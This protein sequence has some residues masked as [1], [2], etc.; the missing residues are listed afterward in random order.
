M[1]L[2]LEPILSVSDIPTGVAVHGTNP[3][4]WASIAKNGLSKMKRNHI[5][6]A[7][8]VPGSGVISG[9]FMSYLSLIYMS[10]ITTVSS[11]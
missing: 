10:L 7:Q 9:V 6:F 2:E 3:E 4:A 1:K 8:N 11:T 5:H